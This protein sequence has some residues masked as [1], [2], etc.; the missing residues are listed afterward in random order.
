MMELSRQ[1]LMLRRMGRQERA[2]LG[3]SEFYIVEFLGPWECKKS[4]ETLQGSCLVYIEPSASEASNTHLA[5][6]AVLDSH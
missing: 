2:Y 6:P 3:S 1:V 5:K 4:V